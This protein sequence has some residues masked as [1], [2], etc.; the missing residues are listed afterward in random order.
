MNDKIIDILVSL[1]VNSDEMKANLV[2][3]EDALSEY[4]D[5]EV[6]REIDR[7]NAR[8][9]LDLID[10]AKD[11]G[12]DIDIMDDDPSLDWFS[13]P[14]PCGCEDAPDYRMD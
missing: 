1:N 9:I 10:R 7:R 8:T 11:W 5:R 4:V 6:Q 2:R 13:R 14:C 12:E 3:L